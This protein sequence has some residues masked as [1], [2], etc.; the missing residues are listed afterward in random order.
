MLTKDKSGLVARS[1]TIASAAHKSDKSVIPADEDMK[2]RLLRRTATVLFI[3]S[4]TITML[5]HGAVY[6]I[7]AGLAAILM[8]SSLALAYFAMG[9]PRA[10]GGLFK[11]A[12]ACWVLVVFW[13]EFQGMPA[14]FGLAGH[15]AWTALAEMGIAADASVSPTPGVVRGGVVAISLP[16]MTLLC[17]L[18]LFRRDSAVERALWVFAVS[19]GCLA[20]FALFQYVAFPHSLM[21]G[22]KLHYLGNLTAPFVNRNTAATFYGVSLIALLSHFKGLQFQVIPGSSLFYNRSGW[23]ARKALLWVLLT[24]ASFGAVLATSSRG[25][26]FATF[27][28]LL[29]MFAAAT[30]FPPVPSQRAGFAGQPTSSVKARLLKVVAVL[31]ILL[32]VASLFAGRVVLRAEI[33]GVDDS[34]FCVLPGILAAIHDGLPFGIGPG[35][36]INVFPAYRDAS[37]GMA[38]VWNMAHDVYLDGLLALGIP[39][40]VVLVAMLAAISLLLRR[41]ILH[42][43]SRRLFVVGGIATCVLVA[44]HSLV[45]FSLQIPGFATWWL[46]Y[47]G[48][49]ASISGGRKS[50]GERES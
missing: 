8:A 43:K 34:R 26:V 24:C 50:S 5:T 3:L 33:Q 40:L 31:L 23:S 10:T 46:I 38:G 6:P 15:S 12:L 35:A 20:V 41:G 27:V 9:L 49:V 19:G 36:F 16:A 32:L 45:D 42:R 30:F 4:I 29:V 11:T 47:L 14:P 37:C 28:A 48:M 2:T 25:G 44:V 22:E 7:A 17:V 1:A 21:L 18:M 13:C 39:F